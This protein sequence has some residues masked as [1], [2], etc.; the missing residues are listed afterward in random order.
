MVS[1][2]TVLWILWGAWVLG[3]LIA[4][5]WS[6]AVIVK[7]PA[8]DQ[9]GHGVLIASG[10]ALLFLR[11]SFLGPLLLPLFPAIPW[12]AWAGVALAL[13]GLG[14]SWWARVHLGRLWS[15]AVTLKTD[16]ALVRT[17]PYAITRHPIYTGL[18]LALAA[19]ALVSGAGSAFL[20]LV[21]VIAGLVLKLRQEE[22]LLAAHFGAAY[23]DYQA[24]VKALVP[25]IW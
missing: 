5:R 22:R 14:I 11:P 2:A 10:A 23:R 9:L 15:I 3:W 8:G 12:L 13:V 16:H 4:A 17:G 18:I 7:Q 19:T 20:G 25:G 6:A 21:L 1:P 24:Q